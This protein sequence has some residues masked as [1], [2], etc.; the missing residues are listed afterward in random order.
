VEGSFVQSGGTVQIV[1]TPGSDRSVT[2]GREAGSKGSYEI[3]ADSASLITPRLRVGV[4]GQG[5][6]TQKAGTVTTTDFMTVGRNS[7]A[8]G[9]YDL[10]GGTLN[11][12]G[13]GV[14]VGAY[15]GSSGTF[16]QSGGSHNVSGILN[17][18]L[19][20]GSNGS[21]TM[22][23]GTLAT[24]DLTVGSAGP[25][26]V[27]G[28]LALTS[29]AVNVTVSN[30][31]TIAAQGQFTAAPG[32]TVNMTGSNFFNESHTPGNV[33]MTGLTMTFASN[34]TTIDT[35]EV[36]G[37]DYGATMTGFTNNFALGTLELAANATLNLVDLFSNLGDGPEALYVYTLK[38]G[39]DAVLDPPIHLYYVNLINDGGS[40]GGDMVAQKVVPLPGSAWL[41]L[42]GLAG[43]WGFRRFR[44]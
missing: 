33:D 28:T 12:L 23:G 15:G 7:G 20:A 3:N 21:Y 44:A 37:H 6:F 36:A 18:G 1:A 14:Y 5:T 22:S 16:T 42:S 4:S 2:L 34:R 43:L 17:L 31:F 35:F 40:F 11:S 10:R 25:G 30:S 29:A 41:L 19:S 13:T 26:G 8:T 9:I 39:K 24:K 27:T 32:V 38:L